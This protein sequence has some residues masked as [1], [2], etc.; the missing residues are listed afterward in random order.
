MP[1]SNIKMSKSKYVYF[2]Q[3]L[4]ES[5]SLIRLREVFN[6]LFKDNDQLF[7]IGAGFPNPY[8]DKIDVLRFN[9]LLNQGGI[10]VYKRKKNSFIGVFEYN[11]LKMNIIL[12]LINGLTN[13]LFINK[14]LDWSDESVVKEF[15]SFRFFAPR[16]SLERYSK[17]LVAGIGINNYQCDLCSKPQGKGAGQLW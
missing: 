9:D 15:T 5:K 2:N 11:Y 14:S 16:I 6:L 12:E 1:T 13:V 8:N 7:F 3:D 4:T 10:K 17:L